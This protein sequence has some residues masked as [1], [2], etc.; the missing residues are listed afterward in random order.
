M[1][2][3]LTLGD[4]IVIESGQKRKLESDEE[5]SPDKKIRIVSMCEQDSEEGNE[6]GWC[7]IERQD[8]EIPLPANC[9]DERL[10]MDDN[11]TNIQQD[12]VGIEGDKDAGNEM[13]EGCDIGG[14]GENEEI[15]N[16]AG[17]ETDMTSPLMDDDD[18]R[19]ILL[20][21]EGGEKSMGENATSIT[22]QELTE[23]I[24]SISYGEAE[25]MSEAGLMEDEDISS[26]LRSI[27]NGMSETE[28]RGDGEDEEVRDEVCHGKSDDDANVD[29]QDMPVWPWRQQSGG[30][31]IRIA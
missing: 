28:R 10:Q 27:E 13:C 2:P 21:I 20:S 31:G 23:L 25:E 15:H 19:A 18:L 1:C 26:L 17:N 6:R 29:A 12:R 24:N 16:D 22:D 9:I 14:S 3:R 11:S 4:E 7:Q 5:G 30:G 8:G